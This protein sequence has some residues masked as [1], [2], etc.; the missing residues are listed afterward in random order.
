[1]ISEERQNKFAHVL[2]DT[3]WK[4]DLLDYTDE[5]RALVIAKKTVRDF[6]AELDKIDDDVRDKIRSLKRTVIDGTPEWETLY[7]KY[8]EEEMRRRG[9]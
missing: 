7:R 6:C 9:Q 5:D 8:Y 2:V 3:A 4:D 1:M